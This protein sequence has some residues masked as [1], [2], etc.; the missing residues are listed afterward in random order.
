MLTPTRQPPGPLIGGVLL[1]LSATTWAAAPAAEPPIVIDDGSI[2][3]VVAPEMQPIVD[4]MLP[5][6]QAGI[7]PDGAIIQSVSLKD[8][9]IEIH[10]LLA[11]KSHVVVA[12]LPRRGRPGANDPINFELRAQ[13]VPPT[14]PAS[15][16]AVLESALTQLVIAGEGGFQWRE[17]R[18]RVTLARA[19]PKLRA[20][21][22]GAGRLLL[23]GDLEAARRAADD[24][25]LH[26][27][28]ES[29]SLFSAWDIGLLLLE[30][31]RELVAAPYFDRVLE[32]FTEVV[33]PRRLPAS[34]WV[35]AA[36][37]N[38]VRRG[39]VAGDEL[40][41]RCVEQAIDGDKGCLTWH[42]VRVA[43]LQGD[44]AAAQTYMERILG[45]GS[46]ASLFELSGRVALALRVDDGPAAL[47]WARLT[48][49][50]F[51]DQPAALQLH[52]DT[53]FRHGRLQEAI[54]V[55]LRLYDMAPTR[56]GVLGP[57]SDAFHRLGLAVRAGERPAD[58]H[59][60]LAKEVEQRADRKDPLGRFLQAVLLFHD[61]DF[62]DAAEEF[63]ALSEPLG[64]EVRL[65]T[66]AAFAQH[67]QGHHEAAAKLSAQALKI[68]PNEPQAHYC[69][70]HIIR[71]S[72]AAAA[73]LDL[74][75]FIALS[76]TPAA[77]VSAQQVE[78]ARKELALLERDTMPPDWARP[79]GS[80]GHGHLRIALFAALG[81]LLAAAAAWLIR[82]RRLAHPP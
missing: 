45:D 9:R 68:G 62:G 66:Y 52:A 24:V 40:L 53:L 2:H 13:E 1:L 78:R 6:G 33:G 8:S 71:R 35:R 58:N 46:K 7:L 36:A 72:D 61:A 64:H 32:R 25:A 63:A 23:A 77:I 31:G 50:R 59:G 39:A 10:V 14:L 20:A 49:E 41:A 79:E 75:R 12:L 18:G 69:H 80:G 70:S 47:R 5:T 65:F 43:E 48:A 11:D 22:G 26:W 29:A 74:R 28:A 19:G 38:R 57:L 67:W 82:R 60:E 73:V 81:L 42:L 76:A 4:R 3:Q 44:D 55:Y 27:P 56:P 15:R 30:T 21:L 54:G 51:G 17:E 37:A 34:V 16:R